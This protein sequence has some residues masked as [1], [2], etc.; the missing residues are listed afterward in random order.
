M[1]IL[2]FIIEVTYFSPKRKKPLNLSFSKYIFFP[3]YLRAF[4][5]DVD[6]KTFLLTFTVYD[7]L[8]APFQNINRF[9]DYK[10]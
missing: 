2:N 1:A 3:S 10:T 4:I 6:L 5:Q 7:V 9:R 8:I